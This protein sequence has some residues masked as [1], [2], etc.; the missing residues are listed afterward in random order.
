MGLRIEWAINSIESREA[1]AHDLFTTSLHRPTHIAQSIPAK[2]SFFSQK[3]KKR[4]IFYLSKNQKYCK[5]N[6]SQLYARW[7]V[8]GSR[9]YLFSIEGGDMGGWVS[10]VG[11][12]GG[13]VGR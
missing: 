4:T 5:T 11:V 12:G 2:W 13:S 8:V 3:C 1:A 6:L 7:V 10:Q 9:I